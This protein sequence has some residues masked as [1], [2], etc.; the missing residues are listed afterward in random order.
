MRFLKRIRTLSLPLSHNK[1]WERVKRIPSWEKSE[2][3]CASKW[4]DG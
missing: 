2:L 4:R 1:M 3:V